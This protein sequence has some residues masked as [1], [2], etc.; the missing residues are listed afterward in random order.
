MDEALV[1]PRQEERCPFA[2]PDVPDV[3]AVA[4]YCRLP[5]GRVRIPTREDQELYC[6]SGRFFE[7]PIVRRYTRDN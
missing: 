2:V 7:C 4:F 1:V 3:P 6:R 5:G